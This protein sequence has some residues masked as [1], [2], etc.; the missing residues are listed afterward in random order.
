MIA[1]SS[2][3]GTHLA[4]DV[5][6]E[7]LEVV[8]LGLSAHQAELFNSFTDSLRTSTINQPVRTVRKFMSAYK[9]TAK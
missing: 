9:T 3:R 5:V 4:Q 1:L 8:H 2:K 6:L 7:L